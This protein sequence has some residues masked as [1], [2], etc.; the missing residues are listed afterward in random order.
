MYTV[1]SGAGT[2][3][4]KIAANSSDVIASIKQGL[5]VLAEDGSAAAVD[6]EWSEGGRLQDGPHAEEGMK[7]FLEKRKP[8]FA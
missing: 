6:Y 5:N 7:A 2:R 1:G 3:L 8:V 4:S